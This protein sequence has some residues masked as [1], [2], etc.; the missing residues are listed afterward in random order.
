MTLPGS[1]TRR[2][3]LMKI[4]YKP[5]WGAREMERV[6][7]RQ[8]VQPLAEGLLEG[9][10]ASGEKVYVVPDHEGLALSKEEQRVST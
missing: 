9:R 7:E 10:F 5:E 8:I 6:I 2:D 4:G 1:V 3:V